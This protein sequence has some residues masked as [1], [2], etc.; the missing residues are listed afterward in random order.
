MYLS[1]GSGF[2]SNCYTTC[3]LV[4][5]TDNKP[6]ISEDERNNINNTGTIQN[7]YYLDN[8]KNPILDERLIGMVT[9]V[10]AFREEGDSSSVC[11]FNDK[12]S[13]ENF[14][15]SLNDSTKL[16]AV[17][18]M[19][20]KGE[21]VAFNNKTFRPYKPNLT[22]ANIIS[23]GSKVLDRAEFNEETNNYTYFYVYEDGVD[24]YGSKYNPIVLYDAI[25]FNK[26]LSQAANNAEKVVDLS[27]R[28]ISDITFS[29]SYQLVNTSDINFVG[30][31]D[32]N[33]MKLIGFSVYSNL[34]NLNAGL[35][36][37][38]TSDGVHQGCVKN[39]ILAPYVINASNTTCV[40]TLAGTLNNANV[41]NVTV[42]GRLANASGAVV[43]G[44]NCV[45]GVVGRALGD[46]QLIGI[47]TSIYVN[48]SYRI[49]AVASNGTYSK[50]YYIYNNLNNITKISY[51]GGVVGISQ[52]NQNGYIRKINI[53]AQNIVVGEIIGGVAGLV[54][55]N[56][57][58]S[59]VNYYAALTSYL[60]AARI[61]GGLVGEN[62]GV[63]EY[64]VLA[65]VPETQKIIDKLEFGTVSSMAHTKFFTGNNLVTGGLV[66]FNNGGTIKNSVCK[67]DV[68]N[69]SSEIVGGFVGRLISGNISSCEVYGSVKGKYVM[70]GFIGAL[71]ES[72]LL[73][74][75][76]FNQ[77]NVDCINVISRTNVG[78]LNLKNN[79]INNNWILTDISYYFFKLEQMIN[80]VFVTKYYYNVVVG[81]YIG[82]V[83]KGS[84][85]PTQLYFEENSI[86]PVFM[87][88]LKEIYISSEQVKGKY[89]LNATWDSED[90]NQP[91][92]VIGSETGLSMKLSV[93][94]IINHNSNPDE[95]PDVRNLYYNDNYESTLPST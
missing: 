36:A 38:I 32:G 19:T 14:A 80:D 27:F 4:K 58:L 94:E 34:N 54:G 33:N 76:M 26:E 39:I 70:G 87:Q 42:N 52:S 88:L 72:S 41:F 48:A 23:I 24:N 22:S 57:I 77:I 8:S 64:C 49:D 47:E 40:G 37:Q 16:D 92:Q 73:A 51:A 63:V 82:V 44:R 91:I 29:G 50:P 65:N 21:D 55:E 12:A 35:F 68:V 62:R 67:L 95:R 7:C 18:F 11:Y 60:N 46:F 93:S 78:E 56:I 61:C 85:Y 10:K 17:W 3:K 53:S 84:S 86:V 69:T 1:S 90:N 74:G 66:G 6:F 31:L 13:F 89:P 81:S 45:G 71:S 15:F 79:L 28:I 30:A 25:S 5:N 83:Q 2:I 20:M 75:K 43:Q 9:P 59:T